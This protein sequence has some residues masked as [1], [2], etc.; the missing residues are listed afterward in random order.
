[1]I[2]VYYIANIWHKDELDVEDA[3][4][5]Q[6]KRDIHSVTDGGDYDRWETEWLVQDISKHY[7]YN[8]DG[9]EIENTWRGGITIALWDENKNFVGKFESC[10]E[11]DPCFVVSKVKE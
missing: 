9:W 1:M 2:T 10:L 6:T 11:Y 8:H 4:E 3:M 5:F 7:F